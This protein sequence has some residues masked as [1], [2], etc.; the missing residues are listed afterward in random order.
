MKHYLGVLYVRFQA[1]N[2]VTADMSIA[3]AAINTELDLED[4]DEV[5]VHQ[6]VRAIEDPDE[7]ILLLH[8]ARNVLISTK[9][10]ELTDTA[11]QI[12]QAA[13]IISRRAEDFAQLAG[14]DY[15]KFMDLVAAIQEGAHPL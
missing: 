4:D 15:G 13:H 10:R 12:D 3:Q 7:I 8:R 11:R 2:D 6:L 5:E 1:D 9:N 14:Y